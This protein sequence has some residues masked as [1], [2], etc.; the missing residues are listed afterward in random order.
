MRRGR[1]AALCLLGIGGCGGGGSDAPSS[2]PPPPPP[3]AT[4]SLTVSGD[5]SVREA[6]N[7][8]V[9]LNV[10]LDAPAS[11]S[12]AVDLEFAGSAARDSDYAVDA[13]AV[14]VPAGSRSATAEIY[15]YRDFEEEGDETIEVS[16]GAIAGN[17]RATDASS[18]TLTLQDGE[19]AVVNKRTPFD[20]EPPDGG[21]PPDDGGPPSGSALELLPL[22]FGV[23]E[24]AVVL[25]VAA[26]VP[27]EV[28]EPVPLVAEWSTDIAFNAGV[29]VIDTC[30]GPSDDPLAAAETLSSVA[31]EIVPSDDPLDFFLAN[32]RVFRLPL[33]ELAPQRRYFLRAWL[34][35]PPEPFEFDAEYSNVVFNG[36]ATD[37][38]GR[39]A[40]RCEAPERTPAAAGTDPLFSSNG[41]CRTP[42]R[43]GFRIVAARPAPTFA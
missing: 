36:F 32:I 17:A 19:S 10:Q 18:I 13:D 22:G 2:D 28:A 12:I 24:D 26:A 39:V 9:Q 7:P 25:T 40:V 38:T 42:G 1:F 21:G 3:P 6:E 31:C 4:A 8:K 11:G 14:T 35:S 29:H 33:A 37:A 5:R 27:A 41:T 16:L 30:Y 20:G 15:V 43:R 34:G 23:T